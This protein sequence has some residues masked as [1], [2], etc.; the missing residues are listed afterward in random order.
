VAVDSINTKYSAILLLVLVAFAAAETV[1]KDNILGTWVGDCKWLYARDAQNNYQCISSVISTP[2]TWTI[3]ASTLSWNT[4]AA[5]VDI[6]G[7]TFNLPPLGQVNIAWTYIG[8][9]F[10]N[11]SH[12]AGP[13]CYHVELDGNKLTERGQFYSSDFS[14]APCVDPTKP[15]YCG[16]TLNYICETYKSTASSVYMASVVGFIS[17]VALML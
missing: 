8:N 12:V 1:T 2:Y 17:L 4:S 3:Q 14:S 13:A 10:L 6:G 5:T 15:L 9:G 16:E 11:V 7:E